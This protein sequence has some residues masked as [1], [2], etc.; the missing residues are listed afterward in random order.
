MMRNVALAEMGL[1]VPCHRQ[2]ELSI[3]LDMQ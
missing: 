3:T 1:Y 2:S